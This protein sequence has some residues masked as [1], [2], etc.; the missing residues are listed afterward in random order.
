MKTLRIYVIMMLSSV[1][2][3]AQNWEL[4]SNFIL[5]QPV[6]SMTRTMNNA[7]G[8]NFGAARNFK[9]PFSVGA[10]FGYSSYGSQRTRQQY[11]FDDGSV[12]ETDVVVRN[13][14][15]N[16]HLTGKYFLR[17]NKKVNPYV[18]G[19]LGWT[20]FTTNLVIEDPE[21]EDSCHPLDSDVLSKDN[22][23]VASGG[24]GV[25]VDFSAL[26]K[27]M[28][29]QTFYFDLSIHTSQGGTIRYMNVNHDP[30]QPMPEK[31]VM[32]KFINT[33]TQ[34]IHEHHVGYVYTSLVNMVE[35][36]LGV[37]CRPGWNR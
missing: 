8:I 26:F 11:T 18:S 5:S 9:S 30:S 6:G 10:E 2:A 7:F 32:A 14:I 15:Y 31:D 33:Q 13:N 4:G 28:N 12:T 36:R 27:R 29:E 21:D 22:T 37:V 25:R 20:W 34:V 17:N 19:K 35:Y 16:F 23:Y 3:L 1:T 24:A